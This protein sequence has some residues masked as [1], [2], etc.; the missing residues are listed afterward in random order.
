[1]R[2]I[3]WLLVAV[4]AVFGCGAAGYSQS[5][6]PMSSGTIRVS[7]Y[8]VVTTMA[9]KEGDGTST[10]DVAVFWRGTRGWFADNLLTREFDRRIHVRIR[11][12]PRFARSATST[13]RQ[14][15]Q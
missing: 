3:I 5:A 12:L 1:M 11:G 14:I 2:R 7:A 8:V 6:G 10:L 15:G 4:A 13:I 9:H